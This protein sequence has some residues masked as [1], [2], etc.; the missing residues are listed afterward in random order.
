[1]SRPAWD[2]TKSYEWGES[3]SHN[4]YEYAYIDIEK[5]STKGEPPDTATFVVPKY[6]EQIRS[7]TIWFSNWGEAR[8]TDGYSDG[9]LLSRGLPESG[10]VPSKMVKFEKMPTF[11]PVRIKGRDFDAISTLPPD[12]NQSLVKELFDFRAATTQA[13]GYSVEFAGTVQL[14]SFWYNLNVAGYTASPD[15]IIWGQGGSKSFYFD[16]QQYNTLDKVILTVKAWPGLPLALATPRIDNNLF[17][18]LLNCFAR[19]FRFKFAVK[20]TNIETGEI[21]YTEQEYGNISTGEF[22]DNFDISPNS[23]TIERMKP[24]PYEKYYG[25]F[26]FEGPPSSPWEGEVKMTTTD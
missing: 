12:R 11:S 16:I 7:W 8:E 5:P 4:G 10:R 22:R 15:D 24:A 14:P 13:V 20:Y 18:G 6:G 9:V 1:M 26:I 2:K 3:V 17:L 19:N 25:Q 21:T 23:V